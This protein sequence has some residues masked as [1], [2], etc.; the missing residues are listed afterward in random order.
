MG[1]KHQYTVEEVIEI[2]N[3]LSVKDREIV[4]KQIV[5]TL[6]NTKNI[7]DVISPYHKKYEQTYK[8][9]A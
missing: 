8:N 6:L 1:L 9:L 7:L 4:N 3:T 5:S 2:V